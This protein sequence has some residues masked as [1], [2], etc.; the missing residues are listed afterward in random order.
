ML[1]S[2]VWTSM[3]NCLYLAVF[4]DADKAKPAFFQQMR[5]LRNCEVL[6]ESIVAGKFVRNDKRSLFP[7]LISA[8]Q[9]DLR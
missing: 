6:E 3:R 1:T 7:I 9:A 2:G 8:E 4:F 5:Q